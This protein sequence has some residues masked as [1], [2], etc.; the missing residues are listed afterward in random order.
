MKTI[1]LAKKLRNDL[2]LMMLIVLV[3]FSLYF[4]LLFPSK[5]ESIDFGWFTFSTNYYSSIQSFVYIICIKVTFIIIYLIWFITCKNW[6]RNILLIPLFISVHWFLIAINDEIDLLNKTGFITIMLFVFPIILF[7]A[8]LFS[9]LNQFKKYRSLEHFLNAEIEAQFA[10]LVKFKLKDLRTLE[11]E[12]KQLK[13]RKASLEKEEY[14]IQLL[15][16]KENLKK[17]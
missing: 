7:L 8:L 4:H 1:E 11:N 12:M 5:L 2:A 9:K 17:I 13:K 16:L 14:L 6:W 3:P 15:L 10:H